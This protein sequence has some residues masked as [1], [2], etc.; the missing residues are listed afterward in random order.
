MIQNPKNLGVIYE[1]NKEKW[2]PTCDNYPSGHIPQRN[3]TGYV[4][5]SNGV[6]YGPQGSLRASASHLS[7][8]AIMLA[9]GG[10]TKNG[11][12]ILSADSIKEL[13]KPRYHYHGSTGGV[14]NDM[15]IYSLGLTTSTYRMN[16]MVINHEVVRGHH[17]AAYGLI[18]AQHFWKD[19]TLTYIISGALNG[20]KY[21]TGSIYE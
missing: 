1:G 19:Y 16:D 9:N 11:K 7:N 18:S 8:Y 4:I 5:G 3:L 10:K 21:N 13:L 15:H 6:I 20:Y 12:T 14:A 2:V 17:G